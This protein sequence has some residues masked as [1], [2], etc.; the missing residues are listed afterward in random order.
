M[1]IPENYIE[2]NQIDEFKFVTSIHRIRSLFHLAEVEGKEETLND[3]LLDPF[4]SSLQVLWNKYV[5]QIANF[6]FAE[7]GVYTVIARILEKP[8]L[9]AENILEGWLK[10]DLNDSTGR[11][12][13]LTEIS[14]FLRLLSIAKT[15]W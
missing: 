1:T 5:R 12:L 2:E 9:F 13:L 3:I 14:A 11:Y 8:V 6:V 15:A 10:E 4:D 7:S